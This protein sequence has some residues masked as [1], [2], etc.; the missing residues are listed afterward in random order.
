LF[1]AD[2]QK[3]IKKHVTLPF[4]DSRTQATRQA[5]LVY[6][7]VCYCS[8]ELIL[9]QWSAIKVGITGIQ[10]DLTELKGFNGI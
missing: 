9:V 10:W 5:N 4:E 3:N 6:A 8:M 2:G 7:V 1:Q